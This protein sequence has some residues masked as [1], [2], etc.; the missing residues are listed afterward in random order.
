MRRARPSVEGAVGAAAR[1]GSRLRRDGGS[2]SIEFLTVGLLLLVPLVYLVLAL[3]AAQGAALGVEGAARQA[4]RVFVQSRDEGSAEAAAHDA[5]AVTLGDYGVDAGD[6][7]VRIAC[8]PDPARCL[9]RRG[10]V[11]VRIDASVELPLVPPALGTVL[12]LRIPLQAVA[13]EQVSRFWG[14]T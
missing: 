10:F 2:A 3:A 9:T 12:P 13:T 4:S 7:R 1:L 14:A 5:I 11:T 8:A 6:A